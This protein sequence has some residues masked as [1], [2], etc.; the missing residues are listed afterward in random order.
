VRIKMKLEE[1]KGGEEKRNMGGC[2]KKKDRGMKQSGDR[3]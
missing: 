3:S 2:Q 1:E